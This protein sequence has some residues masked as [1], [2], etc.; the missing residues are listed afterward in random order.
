MIG[1]VKLWYRAVFRDP[2]VTHPDVIRAKFRSL[3]QVHHPDKG[4]SQEMMSK[5]TQAY[6]AAL[7]GAA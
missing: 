3:S 2:T 4:G 5:L 1:G 6:H 7:G